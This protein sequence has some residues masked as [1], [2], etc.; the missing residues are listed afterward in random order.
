MTEIVI[1]TTG[2]AGSDDATALGIALARTLHAVPVVA[3]VRPES[4]QVVGAGRVDAEWDRYLDESSL[5]VLAATVERFAPQLE[6]LGVQTD[7]ARH[8]S[9]GTGLE[10]LAVRR[11]AQW[12]VIGSAPGGVRGRIQP[13]LDLRAPAARLLGAGRRSRPPGTPT[14]LPS[15]SAGSSSR[16]RPPATRPRSRRSS[17]SR[18]AS[19]SRS[20]S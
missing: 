4:W 6:P 15:A 2:D 9:S 7:L 18:A 17:R 20:C 13:R 19:G 16:S 1:G 10:E 11:G 14:A 3:H 5:A 8:R 12:L